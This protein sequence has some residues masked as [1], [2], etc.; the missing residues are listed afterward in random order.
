MKKFISAVLIVILVLSP[1]LAATL[2]DTVQSVSIEILDAVEYTHSVFYN[3]DVGH[4]TE[5]FFTYTPDGGSS[6]VV[7]YGSKMFGKSTITQVADYLRSIGKYP[8]AGIN[9]DFFSLETGIPDGIVIIDGRLVSYGD[10]RDAVAFTNYGEAFIAVPEIQITANSVNGAFNITYINKHRTPYGSY[11]LTNDFSASTRTS[12]SGVDVVLNII[13]GSPN[14][15][16]SVACS[17]D[18]V[19]YNS[20]AI[21]IP[22]GKMVLTVDARAAGYQRAAALVPGENI[23]I[24]FTATDSRWNDVDFAVGGSAKLLTNGQVSSNLE[25]GP[26]PRS[27]VGIKANGD[28]VF[29]TIDGRQQGYSYG[30]QLTTLANRLKELGCVDAINLDG[31]GST[32]ITIM[33]PGYE[34]LDVVNKP[35]DGA[36]R[37]C[38]N[39]IFLVN[40]K[41]RTGQLGRLILYPY[42]ESVLLGAKV[43]FDVKAT[44]GNSYAINVPSN[45]TYSMQGDGSITEDG[46]ATFVEEGPATVYAQSG[47]IEGSAKI[48]VIK[49]PTWISASTGGNTVTGITPRAGETVNF[50]AKAYKGLKLL[51]A[52]NQCFEWRV[53]GGVGSI[54][55]DGRFTASGFGKGKIIVS[56]GTATYE[57]SVQ[58]DQSMRFI[59]DF[60]N[61]T[62]SGALSI[63]KDGDKVKFDKASGKIN[64]SL[65]E[66][67]VLNVPFSLIP[68][69]ETRHISVWIY[70]D[71]SNNNLYLK[72]EEA[73]SS[74]VKLDFVG[75]RA[76]KIALGDE[77]VVGDNLSFA[78]ER[79]KDGKSS[80]DIWVDQVIGFKSTPP[81]FKDIVMT[82]DWRDELYVQLEHEMLDSSSIVAMLDNN[83]ID[84]EYRTGGIYID[85]PDDFEEKTHKVSVLAK[86]IFGNLTR[87]SYDSFVIKDTAPFGDTKG[88]WASSYTDALYDA[89]IINGVPKGEELYFNP[90]NNITRTEFAIIMCNLMEVDVAMYEN[91]VLPFEDKDQVPEW[92]EKHVK[93]IYASGIINGRN[94]NGKVYFAPAESITRAEVMT[95]MGRIVKRG[96][97]G[98]KLE[99]TDNDKIPSY[100]AEY[101]RVLA[102]LGVVSGYKD[103]S[104]KPNDNVKRAEAAKMAYEIFGAF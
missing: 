14:I 96:Y 33:Y 48:N 36:L 104:I 57:I 75:W 35:S 64:Y 42:D 49:D 34:T 7:A 26:A 24:S 5:N 93:A 39:Y 15:G 56:A 45:I 47:G 102:N 17:V 65:K 83:K 18:S 88:H 4:Q 10:R 52:D 27:A 98:I 89:G 3:S 22:E 68:G 60:E 19:Q 91:V 37:A 66:G 11:L 41:P 43:E 76:K 2:G 82:F 94:N 1:V 32:A 40:N 69:A 78:V 6:P 21:D 59:E 80:G 72:S 28:T 46:V 86:D 62:G 99:F 81:D 84:F 53:E 29:Y 90:E 25:P 79:V 61:A 9:G 77:Y 67:E 58:G 71:G 50:T 101:I 13:G 54:T 30:V 70:G 16:A 73:E 85:L 87:K 100:A 51:V 95:I 31:G 97:F 20:G 12:T 74:K 44:D 8:V 23:T 63:E 38:A 103:G 55:N 92:A